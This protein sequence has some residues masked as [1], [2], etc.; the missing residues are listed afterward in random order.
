MTKTGAT[1]GYEDHGFGARPSY[2]SLV[3]KRDWL[4][5][6]SQAWM[7]TFTDL[8]ALM[9]AFF[10][11]LFAMSQ[12]EQREWQGLVD[13]LSSDFNALKRVETIKPVLEYQPAE[14]AVVPGADLDYLA[15]VLRQQI[16]AQASLAR[17]TI[18]RLPDRLVVSLPAELLYQ[19]NLAVLAPGA[20]EVG[21]ALGGV[22]RNLDNRIE[23]E[24]L[25]RGSERARGPRA[26]WQLALARAALFTGMLT[27]AGYRGAILARGIARSGAGRDRAP[28]R[29]GPRRL[30][31][32]RLDIVIH[33]LAQEPE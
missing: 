31:G 24:A 32:D 9:L 5:S 19:A 8:V 16:A 18:H 1:I 20:R 4:R 21:F 33:E 12:V 26:D 23:V 2:L 27:R 29:D 6:A 30:T 11:L 17:A 10:V 15:P 28:R 13:S 25:L 14:E 3:T 7:V 22:L